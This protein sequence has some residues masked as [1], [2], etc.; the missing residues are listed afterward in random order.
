MYLR[1][2]VTEVDSGTNTSLDCKFFYVFVVVSANRLC[3][4]RTCVCELRQL[5]KF[6]VV[7]DIQSLMY[8]L[9]GRTHN[10]RVH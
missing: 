5:L 4:I 9:Y 10:Y 3:K 2:V 6:L 8:R 1:S 7:S